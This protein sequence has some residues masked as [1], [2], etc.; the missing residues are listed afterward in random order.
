[1]KAE[2]EILIGEERFGWGDG[3]LVGGKVRRAHG[4]QASSAQLTFSDPRGVLRDALPLPFAQEAVAVWAGFG[5]P[6]LLFTGRVARLGWASDGRL[7]VQ[8]VDRS[9]RLRRVQRA[10]NLANMTLTRLADQLAREEGLVLEASGADADATLTRFASILQHGETDWEVLERVAG[11]CGHTVEV[12]GEQ[13]VLRSLGSTSSVAALR[14]RAGDGQLVSVQFEVS[15]PLPSTTGKIK[16]R[17]GEVVGEDRG[18]AQARAVLAA[19]TGLAEDEDDLEDD[20]PLDLARVARARK[21]RR[22]EAQARLARVPPGLRLGQGVEIEGFGARFSGVWIVD[23]Y[24]VDLATL[25]C[26]LTLYNSGAEA[27]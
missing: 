12:V 17:A 15:R 1:M 2:V 19:A 7:D 25:G 20:K 21:W 22:L 26:E 11:W 16:S 3:R 10:R 9:V 13:L 23:G 4:K 8:A 27:T 5:A 18:E 6:E 24:E 14:L